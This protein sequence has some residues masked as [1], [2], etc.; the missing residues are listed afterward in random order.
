MSSIIEKLKSKV[1]QQQEQGKPLDEV[2][3]P[4]FQR[5]QDRVAGGAAAIWCRAD[6][7]SGCTHTVVRTPAL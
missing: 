6:W 2:A 7:A 4:M 3:Q 1:A 5:I